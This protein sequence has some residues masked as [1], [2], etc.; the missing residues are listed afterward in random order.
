MQWV[1]TEAWRWRLEGRV[2]I[3]VDDNALQH[4]GEDLRDGDGHLVG[5][6]EKC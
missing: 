1:E 3:I 6:E 4:S 2:N 5:G